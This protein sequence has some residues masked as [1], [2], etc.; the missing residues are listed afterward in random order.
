VG[1]AGDAGRKKT[2]SFSEM[3]WCGTWW[4]GWGDSV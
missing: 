2:V 4:L 3:N 1:G